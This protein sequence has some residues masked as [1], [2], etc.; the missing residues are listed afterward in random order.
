MRFGMAEERDAQ[1]FQVRPD[2]QAFPS[3]PTLHAKIIRFETAR[4]KRR[5]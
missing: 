3:L 4:E 1:D 5:S 2:E